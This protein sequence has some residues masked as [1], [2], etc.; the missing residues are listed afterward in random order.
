MRNCKQSDVQALDV[1][2]AQ[3]REITTHITM[4][5]S[6]LVQMYKE[7]ERYQSQEGEVIDV[8]QNE[9]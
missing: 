6:K 4:I 1:I 2:C 8:Q 7:I 5:N 3:L 9:N